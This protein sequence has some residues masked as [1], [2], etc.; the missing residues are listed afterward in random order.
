MLTKVSGL[1]HLSNADVCTKF[2]DCSLNSC[3]DISIWIKVVEQPTDWHCILDILTRNRFKT[4][5]TNV[6]KSV[7]FYVRHKITMWF[8]PD[9]FKMKIWGHITLPGVLLLSLNSWFSICLTELLMFKF[10]FLSFWENHFFL[11]CCQE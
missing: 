5:P 1:H 7:G 4:C 3:G 11:L 2:S 10:F 8:W 6:Q 9:V